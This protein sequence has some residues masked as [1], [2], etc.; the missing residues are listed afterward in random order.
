MKLIVAGKDET[1]SLG[2]VVA[3]EAK[4]LTEAHSVPFCSPQHSA[5]SLR[6]ARNRDEYIATLQQ[7]LRIGSGIRTVF[8]TP[9][10][11]RTGL[12]LPFLA[13]IKRKLMCFRA[14]EHGYIAH[15]QTTHNELLASAMELERAGHEARR[16]SLE[17]RISEL[18]ARISKLEGR[19]GSLP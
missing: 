10:R 4:A 5:V 15:Q 17:R 13:R 9:P 6:Q 7:L 19:D 1:D 12:L 2:S 14:Y 8:T 16:Q 18:E 11:P 3:A